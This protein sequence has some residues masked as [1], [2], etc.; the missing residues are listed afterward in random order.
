MPELPEV[1]TTRQGIAPHLLGQKVESLW[2][3]NPSLRWP[4]PASLP[5]LVE[6]QAVTGVDR[7]A[8]YLLLHQSHGT[9][10][11]HLGMSGSLRLSDPEEPLRRHDHVEMRLA[12]GRHLRF[13]D[14]RRFGAW[15]WSEDWPDHALIRELGPEPLGE[16]FTGDYLHARA[17]GRRTAIKA[18]IMDHHVV[19]G[20][21]NIYASEALFMAGI[22]PARAAGRISRAR[23][24]ALTIAIK[25]VLANAIAQGGT[26][27][28]DFI[29][30]DGQPG[31]FRQ[32]LRV[33][34]RLGEPC[35]QCQT[36]LRGR[37]IGQRSTV[38]CRRCQR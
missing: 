24:T 4:V 18:F 17:R 28:R 13:N 29:N 11:V 36:P 2:L 19:V 15:L 20:V 34:G 30:S 21:G 9:M 26:T 33:Y 23:L 38:Y 32:S 10:L 14:P 1:E 22:D 6:G 27:L 25:E 3:H 31:Y 5:A 12:S 8:K 7:R 35:P 37:R 16:L